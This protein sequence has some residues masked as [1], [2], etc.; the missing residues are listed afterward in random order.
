MNSYQVS[1]RPD[2]CLEGRHLRSDRTEEDGM[3]LKIYSIS[4]EQ[5]VFK[6]IIFMDTRKSQIIEV[7]FILLGCCCNCF[8]R[9]ISMMF[10]RVKKASKH[11]QC[12]MES[13]FRQ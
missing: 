3:S 6:A 11:M 13:R 10:K 4:E 7:N 12:N 2:S 5:A 8:Q 9:V 1:E